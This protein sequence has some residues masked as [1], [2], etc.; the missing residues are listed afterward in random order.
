MPVFKTSLSTAVYEPHPPYD[1]RAHYLRKSGGSGERVLRAGF[2]VAEV[3]DGVHSD[4]AGDDTVF[5]LEGRAVVHTAD[6]EE[7]QLSP[8]DFVSFPKGVAQVWTILE[9]FRIAF[10]YV[11]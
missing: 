3:Q 4:G 6:G 11:E 5:V 9:R 1:E 10:V 2:V 8:G 7:V